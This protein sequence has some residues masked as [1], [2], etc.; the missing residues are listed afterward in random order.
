MWNSGENQGTIVSL[1]LEPWWDYVNYKNQPNKKNQNE[2]KTNKQQE[3][4]S[5]N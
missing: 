1:F 3:K 2:Q 5:L 4:K